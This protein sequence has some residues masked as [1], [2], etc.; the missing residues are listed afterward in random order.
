MSALRTKPAL[1]QA[2]CFLRW[3]WIHIVIAPVLAVFAITFF[4]EA[5]HAVAAW[6]QGGTITAFRFVPNG[7][8]FGSVSYTFPEQAVYSPELISLAPY[9]MWS[10]VAALTAALAF[11]GRIPAK[12]APTAFIWFYAAPILDVA[13]SC[14]EFLEGKP[15]DIFHALG[16]ATEIDQ[17]AI[18][19]LASA[20]FVGSY[21]VQ[22]K[23]YRAERALSPRG[24]VATSFVAIVIVLFVFVVIGLLAPMVL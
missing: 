23:L 21:F 5:A 20:V 10:T 3:H 4:H 18:V 24:Y 1:T 8:N 9:I 6:I 19:L 11:Y 12:A 16:P 2:L 17:V 22:Q 13:K 7:E 14:L 15:S